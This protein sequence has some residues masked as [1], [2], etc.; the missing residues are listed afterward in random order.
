MYAGALCE[1]FD[2]NFAHVLAPVAKANHYVLR[3]SVG[4]ETRYGFYKC[5]SDR[6]R[7]ASSLLLPSHLNTSALPI[8]SLGEL[9]DEENALSA[10]EANSRGFL[11]A[12]CAEGTHRLL[13]SRGCYKCPVHGAFGKFLSFVILL[14]H[15]IV[16]II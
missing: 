6:C 3:V 9:T 10:C 7:A 8:A 4:G 5:K 11:C 15:C 16:H 14:V 1:G 2:Q 13:P 12:Q